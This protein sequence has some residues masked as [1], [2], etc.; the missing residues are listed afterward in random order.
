VTA[1]GT[2]GTGTAG[3]A[4]LLTQLGAHAAARFAARI[5]ELGLTP[6]QAGLLRVVARD[7]GRSQQAIATQL[8]IPPSRLVALVDGLEERGLLERRRNAADR[9]L[10][11]VHLSDAGA[12]VLARIATL[13]RA[14][15]DEMTAGLDAAGRA[16][17][18][19]L[20]TRLAAGHG[21]P[22]GV[23]PGFRSR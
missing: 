17:L 23:H 12:A 7:P 15:D 20:L 4:F 18:H 11:A 9:R 19:D 16:D 1:S 14:H 13:G 21:L 8:G 22:A 3:S 5:A 2:T 10:H 6:P